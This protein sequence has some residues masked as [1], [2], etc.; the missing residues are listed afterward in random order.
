MYYLL[1]FKI[2]LAVISMSL[3]G[4]LKCVRITVFH[5][6][7]DTV[8]ILYSKTSKMVASKVEDLARWRL[9]FRSPFSQI[10]G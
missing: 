10:E 4:K 7:I 6:L 5:M 2:H 1:Y 8:N 9:V 3:S